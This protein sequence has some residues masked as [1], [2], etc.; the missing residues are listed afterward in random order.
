MELK[1]VKCPKSFEPMFQNAQ[2]FVQK[3][4][5]DMKF[6]SEKGKILIHGERYILV[7]AESLS[8]QFYDFVKNMYPV[9]DET[10]SLEATGR[11]LYDIAYNIGK[12]DAKAFH[13][14][15]GVVDPVDKLATGPI[16]FS[17]TGWAYVDI[18]EESTPTADANYYLIYDHPQSFEVDSWIKCRGKTNHCTCFMN[19]GYSAGWC[20]ES[21]NVD[22]VAKEILCKANGDSA[23]RFIMAHHSKIE[24]RINEYKKNNKSL[25]NSK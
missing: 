1:T 24:E 5:S 19:A 3:F 14:A 18:F 10:E 8:V 22:L 13:K 23:C 17:Y 15:T 20:S 6:D 2:N 12:S 11:I 21:F 25:F 4:F 9:L 16:H 7:R